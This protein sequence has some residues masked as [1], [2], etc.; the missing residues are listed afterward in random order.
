[1]RCACQ[2]AGAKGLTPFENICARLTRVRSPL[3]GSFCF[4][5]SSFLPPP[6]SLFPPLSSCPSPL[7]SLLSS[8]HPLRSSLYPLSSLASL[9]AHLSSF[10]S[11]RPL[12]CTIT[13]HDG[14]N[15][16]GLSCDAL[17]EH[18]M[19]LITSDSH[20]HLSSFRSTRPSRRGASAEPKPG[21]PLR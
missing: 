1:M 17:P 14:P 18:Q 11:T 8:F 20:S 6:S 15:H 21:R 19:A 12:T 5:L 2:D 16:L 4:H 13:R 7:S 3:S 9:P 10:R